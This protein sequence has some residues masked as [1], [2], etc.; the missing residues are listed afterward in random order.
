MRKIGVIVCLALS[1]SCTTDLS[2][3]FEETI[4]FVGYRDL[5]YWVDYGKDIMEM[6]DKTFARERAKRIKNRKRDDWVSSFELGIAYGLR[7]Q[8]SSDYQKATQ[9]F[10]RLAKR[11]DLD[12]DSRLAA[13][14]YQL[15]LTA[16]RRLYESSEKYRK[17]SKDLQDKLQALSTIEKKIQKRSQR[18]AR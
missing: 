17:E 11:Q 8:S 10:N 6:S 12:E 3:K 14:W 18:N 5:N 7:P 15:H 13:Q 4:V 9:I 2:Q 16:K 1:A